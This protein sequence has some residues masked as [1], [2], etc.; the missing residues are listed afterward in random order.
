MSGLVGVLGQL[1]GGNR[2]VD[3]KME[4]CKYSGDSPQSW[5]RMRVDGNAWLKGKGLYNEERSCALTEGY[6]RTCNVADCNS[7]WDCVLSE[8]VNATGCE[9]GRVRQ[10]R[11]VLKEGMYGGKCGE[12]SREVE[13]GRVYKLFGN[14]TGY[15]C[16]TGASTYVWEGVSDGGSSD[17]AK[18]A[19]ETC[20]GVGKCYLESADCAG[21]GWGPRPAGQYVCGEAYFG[22]ED[23]CS[24]GKGRSW[25]IC[26]SYTTFGY[27]DQLA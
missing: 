17:Q 26:Y 6:N 19:C 25:W 23:G 16:P 24:G 20:Y 22:Y 11:T 13:C 1:N 27:W 2:S 15:N 12:L 10:V 9:G 4:V 5:K 3:G 18:R 14:G 7:P 21:L 8:W